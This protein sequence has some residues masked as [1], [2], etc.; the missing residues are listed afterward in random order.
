MSLD[1]PNRNDWLAV[2]RTPHNLHRKLGRPLFTS[3][4]Y[5]RQRGTP[6]DARLE[7]YARQCNANAQRIVR[8]KAA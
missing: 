3:G 7:W 5:V 1:F 4:T 2:R 8:R 6:E